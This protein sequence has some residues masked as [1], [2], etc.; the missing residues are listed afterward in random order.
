MTKKLCPDTVQNYVK[1]MPKYT[2]APRAET[3]GAHYG[4]QKNFIPNF[5]GNYRLKIETIAVRPQEIR[6]SEFLL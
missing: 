3:N 2:M 1:N 6:I 4:N 5:F